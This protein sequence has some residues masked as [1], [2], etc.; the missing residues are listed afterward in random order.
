[1]GHS[2]K[3]CFKSLH[4]VKKCFVLALAAH[5]LREHHHSMAAADRIVVRELECFY[6]RQLLWLSRKGVTMTS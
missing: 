2:G 3:I 1:M 6:S 5:I 4:V